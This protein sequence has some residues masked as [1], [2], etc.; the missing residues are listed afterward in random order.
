MVSKPRLRADTLGAQSY[1]CR[2]RRYSPSSWRL[3]QVGSVGNISSPHKSGL[4]GVN[5]PVSV[6]DKPWCAVFQQLCYWGERGNIGTL[7]VFYS[8]KRVPIFFNSGIRSRCTIKLDDW[9]NLGWILM[10]LMLYL[11]R[12]LSVGHMRK[13]SQPMK[14][15]STAPQGAR[16]FPLP[17]W[18]RI[19]IFQAWIKCYNMLSFICLFY[20]AVRVKSGIVQAQSRSQTRQDRRVRLSS[21]NF[22]GGESWYIFMTNSFPK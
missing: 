20:R 2:F 22:T 19:F 15:P 1:A 9:M 3:N 12:M 11:V 16:I 21:R 6:W 4:L 14:K 7:S 10:N 13:I 17:I 18:D 5:Y 8:K